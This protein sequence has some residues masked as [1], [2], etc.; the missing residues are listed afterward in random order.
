[1]YAFLSFWKHGIFFISIN[2]HHV[3]VMPQRHSKWLVS[4]Y[5]SRRNSKLYSLHSN[6]YCVIWPIWV[7]RSKKIQTCCTMLSKNLWYA[8]QCWPNWCNIRNEWCISKII[9]KMACRFSSHTGL[10]DEA[11]TSTWRRNMFR[12]SMSIQGVPPEICSFLP[13]EHH[14]S[15]VFYC[16]PASIGFCLRMNPLPGALRSLYIL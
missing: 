12:W 4:S 9:I 13:S 1:M 15:S 7:F 11:I 3:L 6:F 14:W 2:I 10:H 16:R 5:G 8:L